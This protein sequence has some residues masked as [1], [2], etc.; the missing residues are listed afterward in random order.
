MSL[1]IND[2]DGQEELVMAVFSSVT[3]PSSASQCAVR[4]PLQQSEPAVSHSV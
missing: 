1:Q 4:E 2:N 3:K